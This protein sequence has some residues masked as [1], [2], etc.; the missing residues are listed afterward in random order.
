MS[1]PM[2]PIPAGFA[3]DADGML[4]IGGRR[5]DALVAEAGRHAA[6]SSTISP[7]STRRSPASAPPFP[8]SICI[9]P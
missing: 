5:A 8:A 4:L 9:M 6:C 7:W 2:G 3:A 1:K